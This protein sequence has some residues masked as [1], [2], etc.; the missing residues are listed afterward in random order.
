MALSVFE[1]RISEVCEA[2]EGA[3]KDELAQQDGVHVETSV[4]HE[5]VGLRDVLQG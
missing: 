4:K 2:K 3:C 1:D 5:G